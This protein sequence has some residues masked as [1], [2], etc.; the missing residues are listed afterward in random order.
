MTGTGWRDERGGP[1][2]RGRKPRWMNLL[3]VLM[4][5]LGGRMFFSSVTDLHRLVTHRSE[6]LSVDGGLD[7]QQE[8]LLRAEVVLANAL[9]EHRPRALAIHATARLALGL[10]YLFA[11]AALFSGDARGRRV[12]LGAGWVGAAVSAGNAAFSLL[13]VRRMLPWLLPML[14]DAFAQDAARAG[15]EVPGAGVVAAQAHM[16]LVDMPLVVSAMGLVFS[17][18]LLAYFNGRRVR[19]F[20]NQP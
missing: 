12:S 16:F 5:L 18:I 11:V 20:Y 7:A 6:T 3:T 8:M 17:L 4:L 10:V 1:E 2:V 14:G 15:R 19:L 13:V 9:S